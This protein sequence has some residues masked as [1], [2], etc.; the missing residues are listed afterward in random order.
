MRIFL[1]VCGA[2]LLGGCASLLG[3]SADINYTEVIVPVVAECS[4]NPQPA[5]D[6]MEVG[7]AKVRA[8]C[9]A[10]FVDATRF[11]QNALMTNNTT[12]LLLAAATSVVP[13]TAS[14]ASAVKILAITTAGVTLGKAVVNQ[15]TTIYSFG[16]HLQ[17]IRQLVTADMDYFTQTY[18][19]NPPSNACRA[20]SLVQELALKCTLAALKDVET[21]QMSIPSG[22]STSTT[23]QQTVTT[24]RDSANRAMTRTISRTVVPAQPSVGVTI[25][26]IR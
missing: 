3:E 23:V 16:T 17:K 12:D 24:A 4:A 14:A 26:P 1:V 8:A 9:E 7:F 22:P 13:V 18:R 5:A 20:Y 19:S 11:Q 6:V 10:F 15:M 21:Q 2:T 25:V